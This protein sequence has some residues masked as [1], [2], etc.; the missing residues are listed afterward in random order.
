MTFTA[1]DVLFLDR[2][3][4]IPDRLKSGW[5]KSANRD[6]FQEAL[7]IIMNLSESRIV[8]GVGCFF[9]LWCLG[10]GYAEYS[11]HGGIP[12]VV[13]GIAGVAYVLLACCYTRDT[14]QFC[15]EKRNFESPNGFGH[16]LFELHES[17]PGILRSGSDQKT[18]CDTYRS[19]MR[20]YG[21]TVSQTSESPEGAQAIATINDKFDLGLRFMLHAS[22]KQGWKQYLP[23]QKIVC[24]VGKDT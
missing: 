3:G 14:L 22:V 16:D 11:Q 19:A 4:L 2:V 9:F 15:R 23:A 24:H 5:M 13:L 21:A 20:G 1:D 12:W 8:L 7:G 10:T 17:T 6:P 18:V